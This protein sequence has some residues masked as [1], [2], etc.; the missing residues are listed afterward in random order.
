MF[1]FKFLFFVTIVA[2]LS[3]VELG[4]GDSCSHDEKEAIGLCTVA[5]MKDWKVPTAEMVL[6]FMYI[7]LTMSITIFE[8]ILREQPVV[9]FVVSFGMRSNVK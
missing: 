2:L 4:L 1:H 9:S 8:F 6:Y 5:A 7:T 3:L